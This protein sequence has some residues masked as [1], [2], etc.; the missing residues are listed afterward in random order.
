MVLLERK[1][2]SATMLAEMFEVAPRTIYR[3]IETIQ[4]AGIPIMT[5]PGASGGISIMERYKVDKKLFT[6]SDIA[7]LLMGLGSISSTLSRKEIVNTLAKVKSLIPEEQFR[8]IEL[9]S[10]QI[11]IDL[12]RW[13]VSKNLSP[14]FEK[15]KGALNEKRYV[16]FKYSDG[17]NRRSIR[18][19]EPYQLVSKEGYWYLQAYC[20]FRNDFRIFKLSRLSELEVKESTFI[21]REFLPKQLDDSGWIDNRLITIKLL[22]DNSMTERMIEYYGEENVSRYDNGRILVNFPFV[23]DEQGY[24]ILLGFGNRCECIAP[25][26]V[27]KALI[28][29]IKSLLTIYKK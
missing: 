17:S 11:A 29:R 22:M 9:K 1:K 21:P 23:E 18:E 14:N 27:R 24:N 20:L 10:N 6:T 13:T 5:T 15:L 7:T 25:E 12:T 2:V 8:D 4:L 19:V 28:K 26:H 3:D 16:T